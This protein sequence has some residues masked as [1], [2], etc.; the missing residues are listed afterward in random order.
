MTK[1]EYLAAAAAIRDLRFIQAS[2]VVGA[3]LSN[4]KKALAYMQHLSELQSKL[5]IEAMKGE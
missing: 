1:E 5:E 4:D 2:S 3:K